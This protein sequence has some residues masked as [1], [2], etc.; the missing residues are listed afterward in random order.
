VLDR[1][2]DGLMADFLLRRLVKAEDERVTDRLADEPGFFEEMAAFEDDLI[3]RWHRRQL[4]P[5]DRARFEEVYLAEPARRARVESARELLDAAAAWKVNL[6]KANDATPSA[7]LTDARPH[8]YGRLWDG[9]MEWLAT[10][11]VVPRL[12]GMAAFATLALAVF[13]GGYLVRDTSLRQGGDQAETAARPLAAGRRISDFTLT[14][15][16][17]KGAGASKTMD[18]I[19]I[20]ADAD[21]IRLTFDAPGA[22]VG[23]PYEAEVEALDG[24]AVAQPGAPRIEQGPTTA[25]A[26]LTMPAAA[27]PNGDYV[28]RLH[29]RASGSDE[30]IATRAFRIT[31]TEK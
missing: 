20:P 11:W 14:A 21:D 10:P 3:Q 1:E 22:V 29:R 7:E 17:E 15:V 8:E 13:V 4:S 16:A 28:L 18:R 23:G 30:I 12:S 2:D 19:G 26:T 9:F 27:W 24:G 5:G 25:V 6:R 31:R